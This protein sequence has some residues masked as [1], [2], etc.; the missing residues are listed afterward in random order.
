MMFTG[1]CWRCEKD[2]KPEWSFCPNCGIMLLEVDYNPKY[3]KSNVYK[4]VLRRD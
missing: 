4:Q 3:I 1:S 2:I